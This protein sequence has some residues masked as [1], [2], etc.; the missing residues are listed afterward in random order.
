MAGRLVQTKFGPIALSDEPVER[1]RPVV[2]LDEFYIETASSRRLGALLERARANRS[3]HVASGLAGIG[4]STE[5]DAFVDLHPIERS[6]TG[7]TKAPVVTGSPET[8]VRSSLAGLQNSL[9]ASFGTVPRG[10]FADRRA[11]LVKEMALDET[12][13]VLI[14]DGHGLLAPDLLYL[15]QLTDVVVKQTRRPIGLVIICEGTNARMPLSEIVNRKTAQFRQFRRRLYKTDEPWC[16]VTALSAEE[17]RLVLRGYEREVLKATFPS[18]HL[19]QWSDRIY[20]HLLHSFFDVDVH[21]RVTMQ[22]VRNVVDGLI[23]RLAARGLADIPGPGLIDETVAALLASEQ[24][25]LLEGDPEAEVDV[26]AP[27][28]AV[29]LE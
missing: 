10:S 1:S 5:I 9:I 26:P 12:E 23:R 18:L 2:P 3:W 4:K 29:V 6:R 11:W 27:T 19:V 25:K 28:R 17:V 24:T 15:K 7:E 8:D 21:E 13:L 22:N 20:R 16:H 14:D